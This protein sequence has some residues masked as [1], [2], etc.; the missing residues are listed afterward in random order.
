MELNRS[1]EW[2][3]ARI[4]KEPDGTIGAGGAFYAKQSLSLRL[5][6]ALG[7]HHAKDREALFDWRNEEPKEGDWWTVGALT[8]HVVVYF[9]WADRLRL[10]LT[11]TCEVTSYTRTNVPVCRAE[12][13]S[14]IAV[15]SPQRLT[16]RDF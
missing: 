6:H 4:K 15:L 1:K 7:F 16:L 9:G 11:G 8:T 13:R 14:Q 10:L 3:M 2:W 12:S 5:W